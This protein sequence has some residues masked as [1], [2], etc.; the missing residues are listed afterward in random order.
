MNSR[1]ANEQAVL[2]FI[3]CINRHDAEGVIALCAPAHIFV[4]SLGNRMSGAASLR[5][6]WAGY[7]SLFPDYR[8]EVDHLA[9]EGDTFLLAGRA[10]GT[11]VASGTAWEIP[12]AWRAKVRAGKLI[13]W[14]VYADNK[15]VYA[16]LG[17]NAMHAATEG[18]SGADPG[19]SH[20]PFPNALVKAA[21]R[22]LPPGF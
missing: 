22:D 17:R 5:A 16:L 7:F 12:A 3:D 19:L 11:H 2:A 13:E 9:A 4:D 10:A 8:I 15:P 21:T 18:Q 1:D 20:R 6:G 14:Q